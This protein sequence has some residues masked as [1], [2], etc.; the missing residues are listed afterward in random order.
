MEH[1][2][3]YDRASGREL[4]RGGGQPGSAE[5]VE[6]PEGA[7]IV[8]VPREVVQSPD[9]DLVVL[10][11][12]IVRQIDS[13]AEQVRQLYLTPGAG[14]AMT[15]QRKESE[16]RAWLAD[17]SVAVPFLVAEAQAR[18]MDVSD[19][20]AEVIVMA[21]AWIVTGAAIEARRMGAKAAVQVAGTLG[22]IVAAAKVDWTI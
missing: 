16:A 11:A 15:Y 14:Q 9:L 17:N 4:W 12:A 21:D 10:K 19:L 3:I 22:A 8:V 18:N 5:L 7:A 13:N 1:F 6:L 2:I 20:A